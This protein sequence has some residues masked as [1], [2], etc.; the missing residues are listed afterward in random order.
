MLVYLP[1]STASRISEDGRRTGEE[2]RSLETD[3]NPAETKVRYSEG[4]G[5]PLSVLCCSAKPLSAFSLHVLPF[6]T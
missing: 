5:S 4:L 3:K 1:G 2:Q 6:R